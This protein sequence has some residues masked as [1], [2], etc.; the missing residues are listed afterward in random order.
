MSEKTTQTPWYKKWWGIILSIALF[1]IVV[2]Y[3]VWTKTTWN[4]WVK[5]A[6]TTACV[7]F[8]ISGMV[9]SSQKKQESLNLVNQAEI[10]I[11]ENKINDALNALNKSQELN[12][13]KSDNPAFELEEKI[14]KLQSS[15]FLKKT[16]ADMSDSDFDLL[17][18]GELKTTFINHEGLNTLFLAKLQENADQRAVYVAEEEANARKEMIEKQFS[19]WDGSHV[20]LTK[21]IKD[22]MNDPKSYDHVETVYLDMKDYLII[23]TTFRGKNA[24]GGTVKNTVKAKV[25]LDGES[26][27][28]IEQY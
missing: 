12:T 20:K 28:I 26:I 5:I 25:S 18:K 3:L 19:S 2:P 16:L 23:N 8:V 1:P 14:T 7:I 6:I 11:G 15:E 24:F 4:K 10:F 17:Q 21:L 27:E 13:V 22:S 9:D